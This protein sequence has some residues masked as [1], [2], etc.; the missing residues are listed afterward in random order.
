MPFPGEV[1]AGPAGGFKQFR[2][3]FRLR[4]FRICRPQSGLFDL[5]RLYYGFCPNFQF[6]TTTMGAGATKDRHDFTG[7]PPQPGPSPGNGIT[8][9]LR[10]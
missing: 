8:P 6:T 10:H 1:I 3:E 7:W 9:L 2:Q 4:R 5:K